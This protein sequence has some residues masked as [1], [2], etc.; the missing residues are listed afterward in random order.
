MDCSSVAVRRKRRMQRTIL[1][2][3]L[4]SKETN[5]LRVDVRCQ[6]KYFL[7]YSRCRGVARAVKEAEPARQ[8]AASNARS[9]TFC[10]VIHGA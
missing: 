6:F 5:R 4:T 7:S 1:E 3:W 9:H 8:C 10:S 2:R